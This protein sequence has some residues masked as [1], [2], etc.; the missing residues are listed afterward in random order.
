VSG[1]RFGADVG[2]RQVGGPSRDQDRHRSPSRG[3]VR[4]SPPPGPRL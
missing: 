3:P 4:R 1:H 2:K